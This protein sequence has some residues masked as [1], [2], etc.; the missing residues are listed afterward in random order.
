MPFPACRYL[1]VASRTLALTSSGF[2]SSDQGRLVETEPL[3]VYDFERF[4]AK[5]EEAFRIAL[6]HGLRGSA[7]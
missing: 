2:P 4:I 1:S 7:R 6:Q 5:F 3:R